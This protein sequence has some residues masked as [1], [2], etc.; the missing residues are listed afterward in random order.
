[1]TKKKRSSPWSVEEARAALAALAASGLSVGEFA[2]RE[3][4]DDAR[5]FRWRRYFADRTGPGGTPRPAA[6]PA[7]IEVRPPARRADVEVV[8]PSGVVLRVAD[9]I[10]PRALAK[11]VEALRRC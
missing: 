9:G 2:R 1:M 11:L 3:G 5:L 8:L 7:I 6:T 4:I 10:D